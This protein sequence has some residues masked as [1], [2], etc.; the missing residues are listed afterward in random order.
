M[1]ENLNPQIIN[2]LLHRHGL[3]RVAPAIVNAAQASIAFDTQPTAESLLALGQSRVGGRPDMPAA[4]DWPMWHGEPLSFLA[5]INLAELPQVDC[6]SLLPAHGV[7]SFFYSAEQ[8][9][10]GFDPNDRGSWRVLYSAT[11]SVARREFPSGLPAYAQF[12]VCSVTFLQTLTIPGWETLYVLPLDMSWDERERYRAVEDEL[13]KL[14]RIAGHQLLGHP[15]EIQGEMQLECQLASHG[16]YVGNP[17]GYQ[18]SRATELKAGAA[19]WQLLL[20]LDTDDHA[21]MMWGDVGRLFFWITRADL[22]CRNFDAAW[23]ILQCY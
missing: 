10:W 12:Q 8:A 4:A 5:Q 15:S 2:D 17:S 9:T 1:S 23:M 6:A 18:N 7:L 3:A 14:Y 13:Y 16:L 22:A 21:G 20:Q 11:E 19:D